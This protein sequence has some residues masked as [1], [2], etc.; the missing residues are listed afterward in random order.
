MGAREQL[1]KTKARVMSSVADLKKNFRGWKPW[2]VVWR[3]NNDLKQ[4]HGTGVRSS[5]ACVVQRVW[6][7]ESKMLTVKIISRELKLKTPGYNS[8]G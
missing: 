5:K 7:A 6:G 3:I 8:R 1:N 2:K 4:Y